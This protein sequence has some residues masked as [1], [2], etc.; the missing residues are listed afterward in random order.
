MKLYDKN[1]FWFVM[2][3][4]F[5]LWNFVRN[6][7]VKRNNKFNCFSC[8]ERTVR[9]RIGYH[10]WLHNFWMTQFVLIVTSQ[11]GG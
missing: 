6:I 2:I 5:N 9:V 7:R 11:T 8:G 10:F 1:Q 3:Q 4:E